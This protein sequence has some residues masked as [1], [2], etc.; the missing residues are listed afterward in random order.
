MIRYNKLYLSNPYE[1]SKG[2][3][4]L[5]VVGVGPGHHDHMTYRAKQAIEESEIIIGYDTYISLV[6][7]LI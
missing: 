2:K 7:D 6:E 5:Y 4:K 3:G 1:L